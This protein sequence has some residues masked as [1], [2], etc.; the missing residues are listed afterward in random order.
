M[1]E[2]PEG[3]SDQVDGELFAGRKIHAIKLYREATDVG[4]R[5]AKDAVDAREA[6]LRASAPERFTARAKGGCMTMLAL[7]VVPALF[8]A[9]WR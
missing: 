7:I 9:M 2:L 4:L 3:L 6:E 1:P 5:E 8:T